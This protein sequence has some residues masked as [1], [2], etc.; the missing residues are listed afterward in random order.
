MGSTGELQHSKGQS[1]VQ[2]GVGIP[3]PKST[4]PPIQRWSGWAKSTPQQLRVPRPMATGGLGRLAKFGKQSL[5]GDP[6]L[7][8]LA[9]TWVQPKSDPD[10]LRKR[11][12]S[13]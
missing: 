7:V 1:S 6:R 2:K 11:A 12:L 8:N 10:A 3:N 9:N 5:Y 13:N 4:N